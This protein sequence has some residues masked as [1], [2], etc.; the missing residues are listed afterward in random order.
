MSAPTIPTGEPYR[1]AMAAV[2]AVL[3]V[4]AIRA[5]ERCVVRCY[6]RVRV[7]RGRSCVEVGYQWARPS[8]HHLS[9]R[10]YEAAVARGAT[11]DEAVANATRGEVRP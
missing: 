7:F 4:D 5:R 2:R 9:G 10:V 3:N 1:A 8:S 11:F 6:A